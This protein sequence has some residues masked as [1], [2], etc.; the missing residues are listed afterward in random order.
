MTEEID[1]S[2]TPIP[3][4]QQGDATAA[5]QRTELDGV[6]VV[7]MALRFPGAESATEFWANLCSARESITRFSDEELRA[8]GI[9]E[10]KL[11][12]PNFVKARGLIKDPECFDAA[13]FGYTAR[14]AELMDPQQR[15]FLEHCWAAL[16]D[17]GYAPT[18]YPGSVGV[19]G[20]MS[21]GMENNTYLL[22]NLH[23]NP[24]S[25][26]DEDGLPKVLGN[27]N[28]YVTTRVSYKLN[29]RG[30]SVNVQTACSTSL[31][32]ITQ[33]YQSLLT[34]GCDMALAGGVSVSYPQRDGYI[35]Q[36]G[37][38]GSPD[39]HCRPFDA[40]AAGTVFS[41]GVGVVVLKRLED[42]ID[43]G[44]TIYAV[45]RG[46]AMNNDGA[47][48]M[49]FAAPSVD[50]QANV[51]ATAQG[52][53]DVVPSSVGLVECHGTGTPIG[54]PIEV[55]ALRDAFGPWHG[56][57]PHCALGSVK[58]N[59]GHL[60][61][62]AGIAG[63]LKA[64]LSIYYGKIPPT[65]HFNRPNA[66]L[67][68]DGSRFYVPTKLCDWPMDAGP[69][70]A[71]VSGFGIGGTN[72][73][74]VLEEAPTTQRP[75]PVQDQLQILRTSAKT[76]AALEAQERQLA[77]ALK[78]TEHRLADVAYTL[79]AGRESFRFRSAVVTAST[80]AAAER[81]G[82]QDR[83]FRAS[84]EALPNGGQVALMFPG[85]GSQHAGMGS[86]L[87]ALEPQFR[88]VLDEGFA[89]YQRRTGIDLKAIWFAE[90][91]TASPSPAAARNFE[92]PSLQLPAI[93]LFQVAMTRLLQS[94]G[95][96]PNALL[97]HSV[98]ENTAA[99]LA[100]V[101]SFEDALGLVVLRGQLFETV[102]PGGMLSV[103]LAPEEANKYLTDSI[104]L[105]TINGREQ[106]T[107]SGDRAALA[108]LTKQLESDAVEHQLIPID[109]AAHS[110]LL[111]PILDEFR[112]YL[113]SIEL[114]RP[115]C[116]VLSNLTGEWLTAEQATS[117]DY[118]TEHLRNTVRFADN[119]AQLD[120]APERI[121]LEVGPGRILSS[122]AR[123]QTRHGMDRCISASPHPNE[124]IDDYTVFELAIARLWTQGV[125]V[126]TTP[127]RSASKYNRRVPLPTYP[128]AK[129]RHYVEAPLQPADRAP[130]K[131]FASPAPSSETTE[132]LQIERTIAPANRVELIEADI[133]EIL[134]C[135]SGTALE[136]LDRENTFVDMGFDSLFLTQASLRLKKSFRVKI[137]FRQLFD[138]APTVAALARYIDEQLPEDALRER[139]EA[140]APVLPAG[141]TSTSGSSTAEPTTAVAGAVTTAQA[142]DVSGDEALQQAIA[143]QLQANTALLKALANRGAQP[144]ETAEAAQPKAPEQQLRRPGED[145]IPTVSRP[146]ATG[147]FGPFKALR[148]SLSRELSLDQQTYLDDFIERYLAKTEGSKTYT[149]EHR[150]H[151]ADPR[152]VAGFKQA[153]KEI[154][155]PIVASRSKGA[156]VYDIDGNEY[157]DCAGGF[158]ATFFGHAPEFVLNA[159]RE[160]LDTTVDY[161]PQSLLAGPTAKLICELT[162]LERASFCN[163]GS[164]AVLAAMRIARTVTGNDLIVSFAGSYHGV[165]DEV[166]V[167]PQ[168]VDGKRINKPVAPGI[169]ESSNQNMVVLEY[170]DPASIE[171]LKSILD[172]I[173]AV[174]IEPIQSRNPELQPV[175]FVQE[176]RALTKAH[177]VPLIFDEIITGFRLHP[178]GAQYWYDVDAD[179]CAYG[180]VIGGGMPVGVIA[181]KARYMD[182]LDG[183]PWQY[184]DDSFPEAG[185]TYFAGTFVRHPT[186]LAALHAVMTHLKNAGPTLQTE[187]NRRTALFCERVNRAYHAAGVPIELTY[188]GSVF[189]PR[190]YGNP[191]FENLF[192]HHL[193]LHG[194]HIWEGR[195]GFMTTAHKDV[196][197]NRLCDAFVAAASDMQSAGFL[198]SSSEPT[199]QPFS[200]EQMEL[201]LALNLGAEARSAYNEQVIFELPAALDV[202]VLELTFDKVVNRHASLRSVVRDDQQALEIRDYLAPEFNCVDLQSLS[203]DALEQARLAHCTDNVDRNFDLHDGPLV[204]LL[205]LRLDSNR[206]QLCL[207]ASHLVCDGWSLEIVM[208]DL[209]HFY[210]AMRGGRQI[211]R[212][213]PPDTLVLQRAREDQELLNDVNESRSYWLTLFGETPKPTDLPFDFP[214]PAIKTYSGGRFQRSLAPATAEQVRATAK[215]TGGTPFTVA[216]AAFE[217][218]L[219]R[220]SGSS[221]FVV[222]I[223]AAGQPRLGLPDLVAHCVHFLP[224]RCRLDGAMSVRDRM[225]ELRA[226]FNDAQ[227]H[228][229]FAFGNLLQA[230][231]VKRDPSR[232]PL[233]TAAFNM[234]LEFSPVHLEGCRAAYVTTPRSF[235]KYDLFFNLIDLGAGR[236]IDLEVDYNADLMQRETAEQWAA[237]YVALLE[238]LADLLPKPIE[239][240]TLASPAR[241]LAV[242]AGVERRWEPHGATLVDLFDQA[243]ATHTERTAVVCGSKTVSYGE[244]RA[245]TNQF[246][247]WLIDA[248]AAANDPVAVALPRSLELP[249][250]L[251]G[252]LKAGAAY[253]PLDTQQPDERVKE[254]LQEARPTLIVT[255]ENERSRIEGLL[256]SHVATAAARVL[257]VDSDA[258][259]PRAPS[260]A[261]DRT[262][263]ARD[264]AY[265]IY[266]SGSTGHPKGVMN[267]HVGVVN[268]L[269]WAQEEF[270]L[271]P[272]DAVLQKTPFTF[273]VSVWELFWPL[274]TGAT[275]V[276]AR[277]EGHKDPDY[278]A[279][280]IRDHEVTLVH[281]V[282]SML[283]A[284]LTNAEQARSM[285]LRAVISSGEALTGALRDRFYRHL[286][287]ARLYN[288]YGPTE[289]AIDVSYWESKPDEKLENVPIG[290]P[291]ANTTL[292]VLNEAMQPVGAGETG[293]L[294]IGGDQVARGYFRAEELTAERFVNLKIPGLPS[295]R[296][297]RSGDLVRQRQDGSFVFLGRTDLQVKLRGFRIELGEVEAKLCSLE[298]V[299]QAAVVTQDFD[300]G[301]RRLVAALVMAPGVRHSSLRLRRALN[302]LLP[303]YMV[304]QSFVPLSKLPLTSSG[305]VD[306]QTLANDLA[307]PESTSSA[308]PETQTEQAIA[309]IWRRLLKVHRVG[310]MDLFFDL[311]GH[312]LLA[313]SAAR[314]MTGVTGYRFDLRDLLMSNLSQLAALVDAD[315]SHA[316]DSSHSGATASDAPASGG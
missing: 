62:A 150:S 230:I 260:S 287:R 81:F 203:G 35:F 315:A 199:M 261:P 14:D 38:I 197:M 209:A 77:G 45:V 313:L 78:H 179:L 97:G 176:V 68:L 284:F 218:L 6:A 108:A 257:C 263:C 93:F 264:L 84:G 47:A 298:D 92:R 53:A 34:Y 16:E 206:T 113:A 267:E 147:R 75:L 87:Y 59:F 183:G 244:A 55:A 239:A 111:D 271:T 166:L 252:I 234:D 246:A 169:P 273:D 52:I 122:L 154:T 221:D 2:E 242:Q 152:A 94:R 129:T 289:A 275:L 254:L 4:A 181:G 117:P 31:V 30:P 225:N 82:G 36:E 282:P 157:V 3:E 101:L 305:K 229:D 20:G 63:F 151:Y 26:A 286:P 307:A 11:Q 60:D 95:V 277:P 297:Y 140:A 40:D 253:L 137:T 223:P 7:G 311:G 144:S 247:H 281:F 215:R 132:H 8:A 25:S 67:E 226:A 9:P 21:T 196:E 33:A 278:L 119:L 165:F 204:R 270:Q 64:V 200:G 134:C 306:R 220:L 249:L 88:A 133:L 51:I 314:E 224:L 107:L 96:V 171:Y 308:E 70:R 248:G 174:I 50:G 15:L 210:E 292:A 195:P 238:Q 142:A 269:R 57:T 22:S 160:Q 23:H 44:D 136:E 295:G 262:P 155:Y 12:D 99:H 125:T 127:T 159:V 42:A 19:W 109:I 164:E 17:A 5:E 110:H 185:V 211:N 187:L 98:G 27:E 265:I 104:D 162:G 198:P 188:F 161:G 186:A 208:Q 91:T 302:Q 170:G 18:Q 83:R 79:T 250:V 301:D 192:F 236:G 126:E 124:N 274:Q 178:Q 148:K 143:L 116:A 217:L 54:D 37:G 72:V 146:S 191:D 61:S 13:F 283:A 296:Y 303:E 299:D 219:Q 163:T 285:P 194:A 255:T 173:A 74:L 131:E 66:A 288:L 280:T 212:G 184:G 90:Q 279:Q 309:E 156:Y 123:A 182:A 201:W 10:R 102:A 227:D 141:L 32:A 177:D 135:L 1:I 167:T 243:C 193:R 46:A 175:E 241:P 58:S 49:S 291:V 231:H 202:E 145:F 128:F 139:I 118:W 106:C 71:G 233:I 153:W 172:D 272:D 228:Q 258:S 216:L 24:N 105:A 86:T 115:N 268:R 89:L 120:A 48:K 294:Y 56:N 69:R 290:R 158:G 130:D 41:N 293:E 168:Y 240:V 300:P 312:S 189:L 149:A 121:F 207:A 190:F 76:P 276:M 256:A 112:D 310:R 28:D 213:T 214:R 235:V 103:A 259:L 65:L 251:H 85:G 316:A 266:T 29:L 100:E 232:M 73:H 237:A 304:P 138:T 205:V 80:G 245:R 43:D 39:G 114:G 180:K 222:G